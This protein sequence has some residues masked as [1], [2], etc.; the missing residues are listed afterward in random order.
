L[1]I[2][3][4]WIVFVSGGGLSVHPAASRPTADAANSDR[5]RRG[6]PTFIRD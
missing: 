6:I 3:S 5:V 4:D 1:G 2:D